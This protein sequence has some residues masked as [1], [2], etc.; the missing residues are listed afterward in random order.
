MPDDTQNLSSQTLGGNQTLGGYSSCQ[1]S[2]LPKTQYD[3][4]KVKSASKGVSEETIIESL[5]I[6][7][8]D[9]LA[10]AKAKL[11]RHSFYYPGYFFFFSAGCS[12]MFPGRLP[13]DFR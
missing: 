11:L 4:I 3:D 13:K 9:K 2:R 7:T 6:V 12:A 1:I 8:P 5:N 10:E